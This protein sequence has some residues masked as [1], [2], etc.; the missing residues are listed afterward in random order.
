M[1]SEPIF[2]HDALSFSKKCWAL[3]IVASK[4]VE[5]LTKKGCPAVLAR[6]LAGRDVKNVGQFLHGRLLDVLPDP[7][8]LD[9]M[10]NVLKQL[11]PMIME[12]KTIALFGDYDVD[13]MS[14]SAMLHNYLQFLGVPVIS[15]IPERV[16]GYGPSSK[17]IAKLLMKKDMNGGKAS[18]LITIDCGS[19]NHDLLANVA[20]SVPVIILDH[21]PTQEEHP[22]VTMVNPNSSNDKSTMGCLSASGVVWVLLVAI[23]RALGEKDFFKTFPSPNLKQWMDLMCLGLLCDVSPMTSLNRVLC[24]R[25]LETL[26]KRTHSGLSALQDA[27]NIKGLPTSSDVTFSL[28]PLLNA[29]KGLNAL[30]PIFHHIKHRES[31]W[32]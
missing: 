23:N 19:N 20:N 32:A 26:Q 7:L 5:R 8:V 28:G 16:E 18:L 27:G 4:N 9:G 13:G 31:F 2:L 12:K 6:I 10:D 17:N 14:G 29:A 11:L 15:Y 30:P 3:R 25:G 22:N 1:H 21:H 24:A